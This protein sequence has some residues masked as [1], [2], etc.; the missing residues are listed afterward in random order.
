MG[1]GTRRHHTRAA[2]FQ[3][4]T[5]LMF[6]TQSSHEFAYLTMRVDAEW[7]FLRACCAGD[8]FWHRAATWHLTLS[9]SNTDKTLTAA[10]CDLAVTR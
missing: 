2:A 4:C 8:G 6:V 1:E 9:G 7:P 3:G 10:V 5:Q